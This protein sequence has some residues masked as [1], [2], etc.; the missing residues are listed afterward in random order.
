MLIGQQP[1]L[2]N[3][4]MVNGQGRYNFES[5]VFESGSGE[6][7]SIQKYVIMFVSDLRQVSG[8]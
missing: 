7:H 1:P 6:V 3:Q 4:H 8:F 5:C 2:S